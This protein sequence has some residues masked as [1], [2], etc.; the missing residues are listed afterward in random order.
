MCVKLEATYIGDNRGKLIHMLKLDLNGWIKKCKA[1]QC[2]CLFSP[3]DCNPHFLCICPPQMSLGQYV[4]YFDFF[5][6][7]CSY[8]D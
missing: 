4:V 7:Y 8:F 6:G 1:I 5:V 3:F 2:P